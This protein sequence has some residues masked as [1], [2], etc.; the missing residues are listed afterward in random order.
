MDKRRRSL[1]PK[2]AARGETFNQ[3]R[4]RKRS[5]AGIR[6]ADAALPV[7]PPGFAGKTEYQLRTYLTAW[8]DATEQPGYGPLFRAAMGAA[9]ILHSGQRLRRAA[10]NV[11]L[12]FSG[13]HGL[14]AGQAVSVG[15][16]LRFVAGRR[17][18]DSRWS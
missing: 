11:Q 13:S 17:G 1:K 10:R 8:N 14:V 5:T 15:G 2:P 9:S 12:R 18:C 3:T 6:W 4:S 16:E 7:C